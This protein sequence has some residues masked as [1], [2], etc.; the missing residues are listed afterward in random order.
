MNKTES[1]EYEI[2]YTRAGNIFIKYYPQF[3]KDNFSLKKFLVGKNPL[4]VYPIPRI[5]RGDVG[6]IPILLP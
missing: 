3:F 6:D 2:N 5:S 1:F 4:R